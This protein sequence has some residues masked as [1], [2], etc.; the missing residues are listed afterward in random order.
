ML[1]KNTTRKVG[2]GSSGNGIFGDE[3]LILIVLEAADHVMANFSS[4][5]FALKITN[6]TIDVSGVTKS[7]DCSNGV[8]V[9]ISVI[10]NGLIVDGNGVVI[11][12]LVPSFIIVFNVKLNC[13]IFSTEK[14]T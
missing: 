2:V 3:N 14:I 12:D 7:D 5:D 4:C 11:T 13:G 6:P 1:R 10:G 8:D 9:T